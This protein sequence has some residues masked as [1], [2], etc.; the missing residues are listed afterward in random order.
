MQDI[1]G[2]QCAPHQCYYNIPPSYFKSNVKFPS[3]SV[4]L[5]MGSLG[6]SL[7]NIDNSNRMVGVYF[8]A[9]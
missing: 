2:C 7:S 4:I 6:D 5:K 1:K 3:L 9:L 8:L